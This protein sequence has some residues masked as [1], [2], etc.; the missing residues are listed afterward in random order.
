MILLAQVKKIVGCGLFDFLV[1]FVLFGTNVT[2][3]HAASDCP[4]GYGEY[5]QQPCAINRLLPQNIPGNL[6]CNGFLTFKYDAGRGINICLSPIEDLSETSSTIP[7]TCGGYKQGACRKNILLPQ[8]PSNLFCPY[9]GLTMKYVDS[10]GS[11]VC[12]HPEDDPAILYSGQETDEKPTCFGGFPVCNFGYKLNLFPPPVCNGILEGRHPIVGSCS[13]DPNCGGRGQVACQNILGKGCRPGQGTATETK[14]GS[15]R[16]LTPEDATK[17]LAVFNL[18]I[19]TGEGRAECQ[20][21]YDKHNGAAIWTAI[22]CIPTDRESIVI[23]FVRLAIGVSGGVVLLIIL[24][25]AFQIA[26]SKGDP[27]AM[28]ESQAMITNA[29][30]GALFIIFSMVLVRSIGIDILKIPGF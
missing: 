2:Y 25:A 9:T 6:K 12:L 1:L 27:K 22:G 7:T 18:C 13:L 3:V 10:I 5:G 21:C 20:A 16:C 14:D 8:I 11:Y 15:T 30:G 19:Q 24:S 4:V 17:N 26:T 29:I 23:A 28:E